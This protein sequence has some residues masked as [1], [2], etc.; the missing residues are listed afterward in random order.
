MLRR[1]RSQKGFTLIELLIVIA[2]IGIIA[3]LLIPNFLDSLNKAR[4]KN[5]MA[6]LRNVGTAMMARITDDGA[7]AA[8]GQDLTVDLSDFS[9]ASSLTFDTR[10][11][12]SSLLVSQYIQDVPLTDS[13]KKDITYRLILDPTSPRQALAASCGKDGSCSNAWPIGTFFATDY[14]QDIV[15]TDGQFA[16]Y[17]AGSQGAGS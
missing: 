5:S 10:A 13:W 1:M 6:T 16:R 11:E 17:P 3:A 4:Q 14:N 9:G 8:A 15:W 2:I 12:V 7:A